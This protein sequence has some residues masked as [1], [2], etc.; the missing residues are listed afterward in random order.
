MNITLRIKR[1][2]PEISN[3][4]K[5]QDFTIEVEPT[6]RVLDALMFIKHNIDG[7]LCFRKSCASRRVRLGCNDY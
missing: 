2:Q 4:H 3:E 7:T 6:S 1:Y 5:F